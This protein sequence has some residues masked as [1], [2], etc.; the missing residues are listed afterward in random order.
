MPHVIVPNADFYLGLEDKDTNQIH[1]FVVYRPQAE[2]VIRA[3]R[4]R[5]VTAKLFDH[6]KQ[7]WSDENAARQELQEKL[8]IQTKQLNEIAVSCFQSTFVALMHLKVIRAYVDGVL[9]FGIPPKFY[10]GTLFPKPGGERQLLQDMTASLADESMKEMYG[11]KIDASETD[12]F[13]PFV[14]ISL[15]SP[16]F[17]HA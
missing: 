13:W 10:M 17:L 8:D 1:R 11:E 5:G 4:K 16:A 6:N 2:D 15:T 14:C 3:M 12:D 9:R 7:K